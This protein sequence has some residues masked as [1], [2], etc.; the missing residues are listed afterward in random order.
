[1]QRKVVIVESSRFKGQGKQEHIKTVC[2]PIRLRKA[3]HNGRVRH[4]LMIAPYH[5]VLRWIAIFPHA[6]VLFLRGIHFLSE[7][8]KNIPESALP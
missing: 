3:A 4:K 1:M 7:S 2:N 6:Q 5:L 8:L